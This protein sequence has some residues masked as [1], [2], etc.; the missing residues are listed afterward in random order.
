MAGRGVNFGGRRHGREAVRFAPNYAV[1]LQA[2]S[3]FAAGSCFS[4]GGVKRVRFE[5]FKGGIAPL[6]QLGSPSSPKRGADIRIPSGEIFKSFIRAAAYAQRF[7]RRVKQ[8][9]RK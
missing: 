7:V 5:G 2:P 3:A 6:S 8:E 4:Y 9:T 1:G